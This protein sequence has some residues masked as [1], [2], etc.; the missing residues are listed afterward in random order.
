MSRSFEA[1]FD[2]VPGVTKTVVGY[3]GGRTARPTYDSVCAGDGHTA[4]WLSGVEGCQ[5][6]EKSRLKV[7]DFNFA[8]VDVAIRKRSRWS[9]THPKLLDLMTSRP[10]MLLR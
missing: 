1:T 8:S 10:Q 7:M 5:F 6:P 2:K 3:T 9:T 4:S